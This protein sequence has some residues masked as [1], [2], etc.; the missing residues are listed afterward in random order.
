MTVGSSPELLVMFS[1]TTSSAEVGWIPQEE[2]RSLNDKPHLERR[3]DCIWRRFYSV[4]ISTTDIV[5]LRCI[6][7]VTDVNACSCQ[8]ET[9]H[10]VDVNTK[11]ATDAHSSCEADLNI[12]SAADV[13]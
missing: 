3:Q 12:L 11:S 13:T 5:Q 7:W 1:F 6:N 4:H 9:L 10:V 8:Y 2:D